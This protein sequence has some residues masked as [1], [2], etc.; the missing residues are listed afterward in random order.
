[1]TSRRDFLAIGSLAT[2][3]L[4]TRLAAQV[5]PVRP[6]RLKPGDTIGLINPA[7]AT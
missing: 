5:A 1:M 2:A 4:A 6:A 7:G 3:A